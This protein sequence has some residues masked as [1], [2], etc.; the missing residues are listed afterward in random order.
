MSKGVVAGLMG[1]VDSILGIRDS[2]GA[3]LKEVS[4]Y[5]RTWSGEEVGEGLSSSIVTSMKPSPRVVEYKDDFRVRE[6]GVIKQGDIM[7]KMISK[8][9]YTESELNGI[10]EKN[11]EMLFLVGE[12]LYRTVSVTE[13]HLTWNVLLRPLSDQRK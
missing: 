11:I 10:A 12:K 8:N 9:L 1:S 13:K 3:A 4:F 7:L 6:G 2:I 5:K